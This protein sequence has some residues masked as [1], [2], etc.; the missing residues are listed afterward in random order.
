MRFFYFGAQAQAREIEDRPLA[1]LKIAVLSLLRAGHSTA[2]TLARPNSLGGGRET[3]WMTPMTDVRFRFIASR[4]ISV[5]EAWVRSII[6]TASIPSR[7]RLCS[8]PYL[9]RTP[10]L[11]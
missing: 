9:T 3:L 5:D 1:H 11:A 6:E 10:V 7:L 8:P 4:A 2:L